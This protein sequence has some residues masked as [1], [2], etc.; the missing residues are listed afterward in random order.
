MGEGAGPIVGEWNG[1]DTTRTTV[2]IDPPAGRRRNAAVPTIRS[3]LGLSWEDLSLKDLSLEDLRLEHELQTAI[4]QQRLAL[5]RLLSLA[6]G[7]GATLNR[8]RTALLARASRAGLRLSCFSRVSASLA[9]SAVVGAV[10]APKRL[11]SC[12][13][14]GSRFSGSHYRGRAG[15]PNATQLEPVTVST[16]FLRSLIVNWQVVF[17]LCPA[18]SAF[19]HVP[20]PLLPRINFRLTTCP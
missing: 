2:G 12:V 18:R 3:N 10:L 11:E 20:A 1:S 15:C 9:R 6:H 14:P 16:F 4:K 7:I 19:R 8:Q 5:R 13:H 17:G